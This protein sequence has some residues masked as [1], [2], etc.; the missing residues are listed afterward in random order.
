[1]LFQ[2][3]SQDSWSWSWYWRPQRAS[4]TIILSLLFCCFG[5]KLTVGF[6]GVS[7]LECALNIPRSKGSS[8][9]IDVYNQWLQSQERRCYYPEDLT[10]TAQTQSA[11][12]WTLNLA[13]EKGIRGKTSSF[14]RALCMCLSLVLLPGAPC[15]SVYYAHCKKCRMLNVLHRCCTMS[16]PRTS[17]PGLGVALVRT[18]AYF[19]T[20]YGSN[21]SPANC[22][23]RTKFALCLFY[24]VFTGLG[25][26]IYPPV[27]FPLASGSSNLYLSLYFKVQLSMNYRSSQD[28][29]CVLKISKWLH[30]AATAI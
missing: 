6:T 25:T 18:H 14:R 9:L 20:S 28:C 22:Q 10:W 13:R 11:G 17:T 8:S 2:A 27:N 1:M 15:P 29:A 21:S 19:S 23:V 5:S 3:T 4:T 12:L 16:W 26:N 24:P 7:I 30:C